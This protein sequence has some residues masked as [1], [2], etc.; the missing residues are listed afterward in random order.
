VTDPVAEPWK[1]LN[2]DDLLQS[3]RTA[4]PR[5]QFFFIDACRNLVYD[6]YPPELSPIGLI[7][8]NQPSVG[9]RAQ[10]ALYAVSPGGQAFGSRGGLG[11]MTSHLIQALHGAGEALDYDDE[12]NSYVVTLQSAYSYVR[13]RIE[14]QVSG[15]ASWQRHYMLPD[16]VSSGQPLTPI[17]L[18]PDPGPA[19]LTLTVEPPSDA[20][21]V[22]V[23]LLQRGT[24]LAAPQ[25]PPEPFGQ[26]VAVP[27]QRFRLSVGSHFGA[28]GVE[29]ELVDAR[30]MTSARIKHQYMGI[31]GP[32][33]KLP[34]GP[35]SPP[36]DPGLGPA[37][38]TYSQSA[39]TPR[40]I[41]GV[42]Q[43]SRPRAGLSTAAEE[44]WATA[45]VTGLDPPYATQSS[46]PLQGQKPAMILP[47]GSYQVNFRVGSQGFS[48]AVAEV[49]DGRLTSVQAT[50]A[51]SPWVASL[52]GT[53][54]HPSSVT[55]SEVM[56]P[57][58]ANPA[59]F[60]VTLIALSRI[61][62]AEGL[63]D[64]L[65]GPPADPRLSRGRSL[66]LAVAV[67]GSRWRIPASEIAAGIRAE[68][69]RPGGS[70]SPMRVVQ[71]ST[72]PEASS[73]R[74]AGLAQVITATARL[75]YLGGILTLRSEHLGD[76][77]LAVPSSPGLITSVG[78]VI[79]VDGGIDVT[80]VFTP[81]N[82]DRTTAVLHARR[83]LLGQ[84]LYQRGE[85]T[86][87]Y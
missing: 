53:T 82:L 77:E 20:K 83:S 86:A 14:Q 27:R 52:T 38:V 78:I 5:E 69:N 1:L 87:T 36:G 21:Y 23:S 8:R 22:I 45:D 76:I 28:T 34:P 68:I 67:D 58:Q 26:P 10:G 37:N 46:G 16:P 48:Q 19:S 35:V 65:T 71:V 70:G 33:P 17:R 50:A 6:E 30:T 85:L 75:P 31:L 57:V 80:Q 74:A 62:G 73:R 12:L 59:L 54:E 25:W 79:R 15:L 51:A 63:L 55:F 66:S 41:R 40:Q 61:R 81:L 43:S 39:S 13:T 44:P 29:P 18:V 56:G 42:L 3:F 4:G 2:I 47:P 72:E 7:G 49:E 64:F 11:V 60:L 9:T 24:R 84:W 32:G